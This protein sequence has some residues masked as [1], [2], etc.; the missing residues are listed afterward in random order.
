MARCLMLKV[1]KTFEA[2]LTITSWGLAALYH[3]DKFLAI[4]AQFDQSYNEPGRSG[5][6]KQWL[7]R[8]EYY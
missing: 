6:G 5:T 4:T 2:S 7:M 3:T 1:F 8:G